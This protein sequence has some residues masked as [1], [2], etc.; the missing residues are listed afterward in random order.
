M[1][2][3]KCSCGNYISGLTDNV[4]EYTQE[5]MIVEG[6]ENTVLKFVREE[7]SENPIG[8]RCKLTVTSKK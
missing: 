1:C 7:D 3:V 8:F 6:G 4:A 2:Y 5:G